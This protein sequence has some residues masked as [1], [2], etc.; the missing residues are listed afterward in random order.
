M[1]AQ[2]W[3]EGKELGPMEEEGLPVFRAIPRQ[4][5]PSWGEVGFLRTRGMPGGVAGPLGRGAIRGIQIWVALEER[6]DVTT[7][8]P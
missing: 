6:V 1:H 4:P 3:G 7:S 8:Q 2:R 5:G